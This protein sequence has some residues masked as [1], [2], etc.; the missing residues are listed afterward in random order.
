[1]GHR[2]G[3]L[4]AAQQFE[5]WKRQGGR[6]NA[7]S[8]SLVQVAPP[9]PVHREAGL[10]AVRVIVERHEALRTTL[11]LDD[12]GRPQQVVH[13]LGAPG[14]NGMRSDGVPVRLHRYAGEAGREAFVRELVWQGFGLD[15][16]PVRAGLVLD[17]E[18]VL[19][20]LL[21]VAHTA[22]DGHSRTV[23]A[24]EL[25]AILLAL[26]EARPPALPPVEVQALDAALDD[27]AA[28][29]AP[30]A[31]AAVEWW[32]RELRAAP[33]R[34]FATRSR[35]SVALFT[36]R[37]ASPALPPALAWAARRHRSSPAMV[38]AAVVHALLSLLSGSP[39]TLVRSHLLGRRAGELGTVGCFHVILPAGVDL[40]DRPPL[41]EV[42]ERTRSVMLRTQDRYRRHRLPYLRLRELV[43]LE[44]AERGAAFADGTTLDFVAGD[45]LGELVRRDPDELRREAAA[46]APAEPWLGETEVMREEWGMDACIAVWGEGTAA[47]VEIAFNSAALD[48]EAMRALL[49]GP[50]RVLV[51]YARRDDLAFDEV[52][53]GAGVARAAPVPGVARPGSCAVR[54][55]ATAAL[56]GRLPGVAA[57][58]LARAAGGPPTAFVAVHDERLGPEDL[59]DHVMAHLRPATSAICPARFVV[60]PASPSGPS[61]EEGWWRTR[62]RLREGSGRERPPRAPAGVAEK[63]LHGAVIEANGLAGADLARGYVEVG[64]SLLM[65]PHVLR[66][67]QRGG[68]RGLTADDFTRPVPLTWLASRL[69]ES[70]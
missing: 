24:E 28:S 4:G 65:V 29:A 10:A 51:D 69:R 37:L 52:A 42:I 16:L 70:D 1:M 64:G 40:S 25:R 22:F 62:P 18:R 14:P 38:Y 7:G 53:A 43:V 31:S 33:G 63:A 44:E 41:S 12:A 20:V 9:E 55:D 36:G 17:G 27:Q 15:E 45:W 11:A 47:R 8:N 50:E 6:S 32:R 56:I 13:R 19:S 48:A 46:A 59:R 49:C 67:L 57:V 3:P 39:L 61:E 34:I 26:A 23:V 2:R 58:H 66:L 5:W 68:H 30:G 60:C 54:M 21:V 35:E